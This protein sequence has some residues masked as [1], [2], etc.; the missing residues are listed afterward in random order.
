MHSP[1][2]I[3]IT[4]SF[5]V[6][7]LVILYFFL[8]ALISLVVFII[9]AW[10]ALVGLPFRGDYPVWLDL[11]RVIESISLVVLSFLACRFIIKNETYKS[12]K[13][14]VVFLINIIV[15]TKDM[16]L[17]LHNNGLNFEYDPPKMFMAQI[18]FCSI[19][20][21]FSLRKETKPAVC[22]DVQSVQR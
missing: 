15:S 11:Y 19:M 1:N 6:R 12:K 2:A 13:I 18:L 21:V 17:Y 16:I 5:A 22:Q 3:M 9:M 10:H 20:L 14:A 7:L 8:N 4:A